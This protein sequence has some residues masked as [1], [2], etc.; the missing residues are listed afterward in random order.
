MAIAVASGCP[1]ISGIITSILGGL[2]TGL[3][4]GAKLS[5]KGAPAGL[6]VIVLAAVT[7]LGVNGDPL[8]G[9]RAALAVGVIAGFFQILLGYFKLG[10]FIDYIPAAVVHGMISAIGLIVMAKQIYFLLGMKAVGK[11][12]VELLSHLFQSLHLANPLIAMIGL[13]SLVIMVCSLHPK[14]KRYFKLPGALVVLLFAIGVSFVF[15]LGTSTSYQFMGTNYKLDDSFLIHLPNSLIQG[16]VIPDWS[17]LGTL[18]AWK[19]IFLFAVIG[20]IESL[21]TV[22]AINQTQGPDEQANLNKDLISIGV[23]NS[24]AGMIGGIPMISEIGR[25]KA[26]IDFGATSARSNLIHG[27][28]LVVAVV[29]FASL[30]NH[31]PIA[32]LA[33]ILIFIGYRLFSITEWKHSW[34]QGKAIFAVFFVTFAVTVAVD[35]LAGVLIGFILYLICE[36]FKCHSLKRVFSPKFI[37]EVESEQARISFTEGLIFTNFPKVKKVTENALTLHQTVL[38]DCQQCSFIDDEFMQELNNYVAAT[39]RV[40]KLS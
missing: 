25:S 4:G 13:V 31:V 21:L 23:V 16:L 8:S 38:I 20:C 6:I 10:K 19:F 34:Q 3:I 9:Y 36:S 29:F 40:Q 24:L 7:E 35:L 18:T 5:I 22:K 12:P 37:I 32:A 1:P 17:T 14:L 28:L 11:S 15:Q 27:A 2:L 39:T 26:N 30:L 33:A